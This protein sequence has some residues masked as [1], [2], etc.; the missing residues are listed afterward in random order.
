MRRAKSGVA[1]SRWAASWKSRRAAKASGWTSLA[2]KVSTSSRAKAWTSGVEHVVGVPPGLPELFRRLDPG[3]GIL[4]L[5]RGP[6]DVRRVGHGVAEDAA[7]PAV[8]PLDPLGDLD[9]E[10]GQRGRLVEVAAPSCLRSRPFQMARNQMTSER[11]LRTIP[12]L[13]ED[14]AAWT[15]EVLHGDPA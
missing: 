14:E 6:Q 12:F 2:S 11:K 13:H 4:Q 9:G 5:A 3:S 1:S 15:T 10:P 7:A 8:R